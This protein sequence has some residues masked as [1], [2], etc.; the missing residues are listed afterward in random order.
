MRLIYITTRNSGEAKKI[1]SH[2]LT[3]KIVA[4]VNIFPIES[5]YWLNAEIQED[6]E[7]VIIAKTADDK[8]DEVEAEVLKLHTYQIPAIFSWKIDK[9]SKKY[10]EWIKKEIKK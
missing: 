8:F 5:M 7:F 1:S 2:L 10:G 4:C 3:K 9:V 6:I